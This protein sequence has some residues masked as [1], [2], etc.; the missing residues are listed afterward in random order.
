ML[1]CYKR[2][3]KRMVVVSMKMKIRCDFWVDLDNPPE[4]LTELVKDD[5]GNFTKGTAKDFCY[6]DKLRYIDMIKHA[7]CGRKDA[8]EIVRDSI[9]GLVD[10][11]LDNDGEWPDW[12]EIADEEFISYCV[13]KGREDFYNHDLSSR[14]REIIYSMIKAVIEY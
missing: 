6:E 4:N 13:E 1:A 8:N 9:H 3:E 7:T 10:S 11:C 12:S 14:H 2:K 5:F